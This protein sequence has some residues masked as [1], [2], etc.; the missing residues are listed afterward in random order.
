MGKNQS[1]SAQ[2]RGYPAW[3]SE[4]SLL[5]VHL[6]I[7]PGLVWRKTANSAVAGQS[8]PSKQGWR[9]GRTYITNPSD[10]PGS[11]IGP[12][13]YFWEVRTISITWRTHCIPAGRPATYILFQ[14]NSKEGVARRQIEIECLCA[15]LRWPPIN[16]FLGPRSEKALGVALRLQDGGWVGWGRIWMSETR[17]CV[18]RHGLDLK[19]SNDHFKFSLRFS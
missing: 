12:F 5:A 11:S 13:A 14:R 8:M 16:K 1:L 17:R 3:N 7:P 9:L 4:I 6:V 15:L 2:H 18:D 10:F 19:I